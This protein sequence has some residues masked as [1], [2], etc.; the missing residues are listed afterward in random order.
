MTIPAHPH[1]TP[2]PHSLLAAL[3][4]AQASANPQSAAEARA[5]LIA[6]GVIKERTPQKAEKPVEQA[7]FF[8]CIKFILKRWFR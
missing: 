5:K 1:R 7:G 4:Q 2:A 8:A 3:P 6:Q